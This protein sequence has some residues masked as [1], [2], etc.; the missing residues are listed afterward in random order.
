M[1]FIIS[2]TMTVSRA[3]SALLVSIWFAGPALAPQQ[4]N[5]SQCMSQSEF[6]CRFQNESQSKPQNKSPGIESWSLEQANKR[7]YSWHVYLSNDG[8]I[9]SSAQVPF[10][11]MAI[12]PN[13]DVSVYNPTTKRYFISP[14][15]DWKRTKGCSSAASSESLSHPLGAHLTEEA[16]TAYRAIFILVSFLSTDDPEPFEQV[17]KVFSNAY[18]NANAAKTGSNLTLTPE[19]KIAFNGL[20]LSC[21]LTDKNKKSTTVVFTNSVG[22]VRLPLTFFNPPSVKNFKRV[23]SEIAAMMDE[24]GIA[25]MENILADLGEEDSRD[26]DELLDEAPKATQKAEPRADTKNAKG[27]VS[28]MDGERH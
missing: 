8:V 18:C 25:A 20:S 9:F 15:S 4:S 23:D 21:E 22:K 28:P 7:G 14:L 1:S 10:T 13:W 17:D 3:T 19:Q 6:S 16:E 27:A 12:A 11:I 2:N 24:E 26:L 5:K